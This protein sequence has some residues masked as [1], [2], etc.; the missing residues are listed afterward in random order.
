M[1]LKCVGTVCVI[2]HETNY[3]C[4]TGISTVWWDD[5]DTI[6]GIKSWFVLCFVLCSGTKLNLLVH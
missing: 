1:S 4:S 5:G 2:G 3:T 6:L